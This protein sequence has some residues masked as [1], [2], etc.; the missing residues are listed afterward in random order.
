MKFK[1]T[2]CLHGDLPVGSATCE[3]CHIDAHGAVTG[4]VHID[5]QANDDLIAACK[6]AL[7]LNEG[8]HTHLTAEHV[9]KQ[10]REAIQ[11]AEG[12]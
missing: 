11:K 12:E 9:N 2:R 8:S 6:A 7:A 5:S 1:C 4:Y 3:E 10:L